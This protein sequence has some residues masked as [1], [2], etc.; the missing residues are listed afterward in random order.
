[1]KK[2]PENLRIADAP[3][4]VLLSTSGRIARTS[5]AAVLAR[6]G[7][8]ASHDA[9]VSEVVATTQG[10]VGALTSTG[11][12]H[13]IDV[14]DLPALPPGASRPNVAG[15]VKVAEYAALEKNEKVIGLIDLEREF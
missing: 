11:T 13:L 4:R 7:K 14:V 10:K 3:T 12:L 15:G 1:G 9:L 6:S 2:A 5:D 8:R